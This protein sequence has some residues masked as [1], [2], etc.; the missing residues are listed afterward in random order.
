[1]NG[2][3]APFPF[4]EYLIYSTQRHYS[5]SEF[6]NI[7]GEFYDDAKR[8]LTNEPTVELYGQ[9]IACGYLLQ[10]FICSPSM[11]HSTYVS[12]KQLNSTTH[13]L[14]GLQFVNIRR[15]QP[16]PFKGKQGIGFLSE[17]DKWKI[18]FI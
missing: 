13:T 16:F 8:V 1:M 6:K 15:I 3:K 18:K 11:M 7:S 9:A 2:K 12:A 4:G 5:E 17:E 10:K 14:W